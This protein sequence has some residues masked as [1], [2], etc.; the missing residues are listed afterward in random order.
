MNGID[1]LNT[2][3]V[4][5]SMFRKNKT[6]VIHHDVYVAEIRLVYSNIF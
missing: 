4:N 2:W 3:L 1:N 6:T 5:C